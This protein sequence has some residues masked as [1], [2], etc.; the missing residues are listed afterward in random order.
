MPRGTY[1]RKNNHTNKGMSFSVE[2]RQNLSDKMK[3][4]TNAHGNKGKLHP[5]RGS[6][7]L[8]GE[9]SPNWKG[10]KKEVHKRANFKRE[11][12]FG[13]VPL[14]E[15]FEGADAHHLDKVYVIYMDKE[16][17]RSI[18]HSVLKNQNMNE[19]NAIAFNYI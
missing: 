13:F 6:P 12:N 11:H 17:H 16:V 19:I 7:R 15:Y 3:G 10:G 18:K 5:H 9:K 2:W 8:F 14:N 4:N 1:D